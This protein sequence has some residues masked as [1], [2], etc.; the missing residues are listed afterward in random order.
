MKL[1]A[2]VAASSSLKYQSGV[3]PRWRQ[4]VFSGTLGEKIERKAPFTFLQTQTGVCRP[5]QPAVVA[6]CDLAGVALWRTLKDQASCMQR[7]L[8]CIWMIVNHHS[9]RPIFY[10]AQG[11]Y[12]DSMTACKAAVLHRHTQ[13]SLSEKPGSRTSRTMPAAVAMSKPGRNGMSRTPSART[14]GPAA[15]SSTGLTVRFRMAV[16]KHH[17]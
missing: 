15:A 7:D 17:S 13:I 4:G 1:A 3:L 16:C 8:G 6:K 14:A 11:T 2:A 9:S 10:R 5:V 12:S